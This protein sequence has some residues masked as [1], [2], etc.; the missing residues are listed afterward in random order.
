VDR[1]FSLTTQKTATAL[2]FSATL[3]VL[4]HKMNKAEHLFKDAL[5]ISVSKNGKEAKYITYYC[6]CYLC[7]LAE[8]ANCDYFR[9][10]ALNVPASKTMKRWLPLPERSVLT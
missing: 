7:I 1:Y 9:I 6:K 3:F 2:A 5:A 8:E 4:E 10:K